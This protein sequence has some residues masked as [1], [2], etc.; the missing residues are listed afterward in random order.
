[1]NVDL[2]GNIIQNDVLLKDK[3]GIIPF[4]VLDSKSAE[5]KKR[6]K[7]WL[8]KGIKSEIGRNDDLLGFKRVYSKGN[9]RLFEERNT[10]IFCPVLTELIYRWFCIKNGKILDPFAGGSVRGIVAN[11]LGYKY[12]GIELREEQVKSNIEQANDILKNIPNWIIGDSEYILQNN[13]NELYDLIFTCPPYFDLEVYSSLKSDLSNMDFDNFKIKY[14]NILN[15]SIS[16]LKNNR[17][18]CI[19]IGDVRDK[20]RT[21]NWYRDLI[22]LTKNILLKNNNVHLYNDI[23]MLDNIGTSAMRVEQAFSK[24]KLVKI[25]QNILVFYKGNNVNDIKREFEQY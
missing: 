8:S 21:Q 24:R 3:F 19:V 20:D 18:I 9:K 5:W 16:K 14:E 23:I 11:Y 10:S 12:T 6:K 7:I 22:G 1:M 15:S 2:F 17:F 4:S 25:H 13:I